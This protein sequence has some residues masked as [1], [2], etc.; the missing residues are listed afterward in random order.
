MSQKRLIM[1]AI[2][3][4]AFFIIGFL[5]NRGYLENTIDEEVYTSTPIESNIIEKIGIIDDYRRIG[6]SLDISKNDNDNV[7]TLLSYALDRDTLILDYNLKLNSSMDFIK[8]LSHVMVISVDGVSYT[9]ED[10][11]HSN[12]E[13]FDKISDTEYEVCKIIKLDSDDIKDKTSC[14]FKVFLYRDTETIDSETVAEWIFEFDIDKK[15]IS[16][17]NK[18][19]LT[20]N[21]SEN[22]K[23]V[24]V[25]Q[26]DLGTKFS[27]ILND[28]TTEPDVHYYVEIL[29][30]KGNEIL[31]PNLEYLVGG[32]KTDIITKKINLDEKL[33]FNIYETFSNGENNKSITF[34]IDLSKYLKIKEEDRISLKEN[35]WKDISFEYPNTCLVTNDPL[36]NKDY[37]SISYNNDYAEGIIY[38]SR[39]DNIYKRNL[40]EIAEDFQNLEYLGGYGLFDNYT[41]YSYYDGK[42]K[43][44]DIDLSFYELMELAKNKTVTVNGEKILIENVGIHDF[45]VVNQ[46]NT[47][48][49]GIPAIMWTEIDYSSTTRIVFL[50]DNSIYEIKSSGSIDNK[51]RFEN[52]INSIKVIK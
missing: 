47:N 31:Q 17:F 21:F 32:V 10:F 44:H 29:D 19:E 18:Y 41:I 48:I 39:Y 34:D 49:D 50:K 16:V 28:Y 23:V 11:D 38:I 15:D 35:K 22:A 14:N 5:V 2:T 37:L 1:Y 26:T 9:I 52:L 43:P 6:K 7:L 12:I 30:E 33:T 36:S 24:E 4:I 46:K 42:N 51:N 20:R 27:I 13:I 3:I 40:N 8:N 45:E 25:T